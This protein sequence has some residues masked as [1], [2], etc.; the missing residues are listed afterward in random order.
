MLQGTEKI[1]DR[2]QYIEQLKCK[3]EVILTSF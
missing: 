1:V 2:P 3:Y